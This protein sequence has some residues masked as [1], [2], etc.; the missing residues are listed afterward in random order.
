[1]KMLKSKNTLGGKET[2][3]SEDGRMQRI[4]L[5]FA[6]PHHSL[7]FSSFC[8]LPRLENACNLYASSVTIMH[9]Q[10]ELVC[11]EFVA[12]CPPTHPLAPSLAP[13][14]QSTPTPTPTPWSRLLT[15]VAMREN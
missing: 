13:A 9:L 15:G 8:Y 12:L 6:L 4:P 5:S 11:R 10:F 3:S 7:L 1:M 2:H 14:S